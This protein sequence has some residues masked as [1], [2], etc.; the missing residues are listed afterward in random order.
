MRRGE[1]QVPGRGVCFNNMPGTEIISIRRL[2]I[3]TES[4]NPMHGPHAY[5]KYTPTTM[6]AGVVTAGLI[7]LFKQVP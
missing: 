3:S 2:L 1:I 7:L 4:S 5:I 6:S